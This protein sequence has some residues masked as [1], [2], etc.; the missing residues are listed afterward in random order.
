[1]MLYGDG[2]KAFR[3]LQLEIIPES[4]DHSILV[5]NSGQAVSM[6]ESRGSPGALTVTTKSLPR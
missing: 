2:R 6:I 3:R 5:W 1:M 4:S